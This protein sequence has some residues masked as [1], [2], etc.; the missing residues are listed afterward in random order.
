MLHCLFKP[1]SVAVVGASNRKLTIGYRILQNLSDSGYK[2]PVY[3]VHPKEDTI[4]GVKAYRSILDVPGS[5]DVAHIV[6][7]NTLVPEVLEECGRKK[8]KSVIINT[9]GFGEVGGEG[10]ELEKKIL[11]IAGKAN[12]R[13]F[14]PNCQGIMNSDP[15]VRAYC[16]F[17]FTRLTR[18][19][20]SVVAQSGGVGEVIIQRLYSLGEGFRMFASNGN[21]ADISIPEIIKYW[22]D[23]EGTK[24][25]IVHIESLAD[26]KDFADIAAE[27]ARK[28]PV[29]G[30]KTGRTTEGAKA[31][32]SHTGRL[33]GEEIPIE[34]IMEKCG[35]VSFKDQ[36]EL[37]QAAIAFAKQPLPKGKRVAIVTNS[38]GPGIIATDGCIEAGLELAPLSDDTRKVLRNDLFPEATVSNPVD[39]LATATPEHYGLTL[40]ELMKDPDIDSILVNFIT[41]FFVDCEGVAREIVKAS[42]KRE[43]PVVSVIMTDKEQ[44]GKTLQVIKEGG[45]PVY[46]FAEM[47]AKALGAMTRMSEYRRRDTETPEPFQDVDK[48][49]ARSVVTAALKAGRHILGAGECSRI[50][51]SY[52]I[53]RAPAEFGRNL[54]ECLS[55][56]GKIGFPVALKIDS[57]DL[58]HKTESGALSLNIRDEQGLR[59]EFN[60]LCARFKNADPKY[61]VQKYLTGG[62]EVIAGAKAV[63]GVGHVLMFGFG[64][65]HVEIMKDVVFQFAPLSKS[66][67][68]RMV[69]SV[70]CSPILEGFRGK[71][72]ANT[73]R[74]VEILLRLSQLVTDVPELGELDLN[75]IIAYRDPSMTAAVDARIKIS[76][77]KDNGRPLA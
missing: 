54:Q 64:G 51:D 42:E 29:L 19:T 31:V 63:A 16:N 65:I 70:K 71:D 22:G 73:E 62:I 6:V 33:M 69:G 8:V 66:G 68:R 52:G 25:I 17:T 12:V 9:A 77:G 18:G 50:L 26:P 23:D 5:V 32:V 67:A 48:D 56:A 2:G 76:G 45:I 36:D 75:P 35:I 3:P 44:Q 46:D 27:V 72:G 41:P 21:A 11:E 55:A 4:R 49:S 39:V 7:K 37:C 40:R 61:L 28:K 57:F 15:E 24:V 74:L 14:G 47:A 13:I 30:I 38:G 1:K 58:V 34:L 53:P 60:D 43:K 59:K 10:I 20:I